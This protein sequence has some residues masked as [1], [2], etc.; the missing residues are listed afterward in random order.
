M[1]CIT[2]FWA[3]QI[4]QKRNWKEEKLKRERE[5]YLMEINRGNSPEKK[6]WTG[7]HWKKGCVGSHSTR[8]HSEGKEERE[9][10]G[11]EHKH[12]TCSHLSFPVPSYVFTFIHSPFFSPLY[13]QRKYSENFPWHRASD[14]SLSLSLS[15]ASYNPPS[16]PFSGKEKMRKVFF[17]PSLLLY[18]SISLSLSTSRWCFGSTRVHLSLRSLPFFQ[19]LQERERVFWWWKVVWRKKEGMKKVLSFIFS[20]LLFQSDVGEFVTCSSNV[21][22]L[23]P[24]FPFCLPFLF[25]CLLS[26]RESLPSSQSKVYNTTV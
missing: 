10:K 5:V 22:F 6:M 21:R 11:K 7:R 12:N 4:K 16:C 24:F 26:S 15:L 14:L 13:S 2:N 19:S 17:S 1:N 8:E 20:R 3:I 23:P 25:L 9:R 18:L